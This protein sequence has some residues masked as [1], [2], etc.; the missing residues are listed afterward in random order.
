MISCNMAAGSER[1]RSAHHETLANMA[2]RRRRC[3]HWRSSVLCYLEPLSPL[4]LRI[5]NCSFLPD[6][7]LGDPTVSD[8]RWRIRCG[9]LVSLPLCPSGARITHRRLPSRRLRLPARPTCSPPVVRH[10][11]LRRGRRSLPA[12]FGRAP[13]AADLPRGLL[14]HYLL[15]PGHHE[16]RNG[17]RWR[18][19]RIQL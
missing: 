14:S 17:T 3:R 16:C 5:G 19:E 2:H 7:R 18:I 8:P 12:F 1:G 9:P 6:C 4:V 10:R 15:G 13:Q 11:S